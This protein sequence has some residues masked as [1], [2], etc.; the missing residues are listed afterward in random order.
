MCSLVCPRLALTSALTASQEMA[1]EIQRQNLSQRIPFKN[2]YVAIA[3]VFVYS[4]TIVIDFIS[5][6]S[7]ISVWCLI[8][9]SLPEPYREWK[10]TNAAE[11]VLQ[12]HSQKWLFTRNLSNQKRIWLNFYLIV[13]RQ[14]LWCY[15]EFAE[16]GRGGRVPWRPLAIRGWIQPAKDNKFST[17]FFG[18]RGGRL[19]TMSPP[20]RITRSSSANLPHLLSHPKTFPRYAFLLDALRLWLIWN[21]S[22]Q[23]ILVTFWCE[24]RKH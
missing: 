11:T 13:E 5:D 10:N 15:V 3:A 21:S 20:C 17:V 2:R 12:F 24:N 6:E 1:K 7:K 8:S 19:P 18:R 23:R 14:T 16:T 9:G 22:K 4:S